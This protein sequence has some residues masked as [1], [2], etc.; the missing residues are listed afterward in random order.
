M[1]FSTGTARRSAAR[2]AGATART[3]IWCAPLLAV[4]LIAA[5]PAHAARID[6]RYFLSVSAYKPAIKTTLQ[7]S[8]PGLPIDGTAINLEEDL[9]MADSEWLPAIE[10]GMRLGKRWRIAGEY[11]R[12]SRSANF[13]L[14]RNIIWDDTTYDLG[15]DVASSF[16]TTVYRAAIGYS[17][18][19]K[20]Q[21][22][23]GVDLGAHITDFAASISGVGRVNAIVQPVSQQRQDQLVPLPTIGAYVAWDIDKTFSLQGRVDWLSLDVGDYSGGLTYVWATANARLLPHV[24]V[25]VGWRY[26]N[27]HI[28]IARPDWS[29]FVRY[30]YSGPA[31]FLNLGF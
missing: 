10:I 6:D 20:P 29:G 19:K 8:I 1:N 4:A 30:K 31:F 2:P 14:Q 15:V 5:L 27:Y 17:L 21:W 11:Y 25:G 12:L 3:G 23:L 9:G 18:V 13:T 7:A 26:V 24:G 16:D 22:E 28:D